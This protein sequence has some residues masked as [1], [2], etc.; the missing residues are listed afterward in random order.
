MGPNSGKVRVKVEYHLLGKEDALVYLSKYKFLRPHD[1]SRWRG[2][3]WFLGLEEGDF[4]SQTN[5]APE[6]MFV[7][8]KFDE[9]QRKFVVKEIDCDPIHWK[10]DGDNRG[11]GPDEICKKK[12]LYYNNC[13]IS[14]HLMMMADID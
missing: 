2:E 8:E 12:C 4:V 6:G 10:G 3:I 1:P 13:P 5:E 9:S 7:I 14:A 11:R